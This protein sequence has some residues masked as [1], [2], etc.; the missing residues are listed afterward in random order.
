M[1]SHLRSELLHVVHVYLL[2]SVVVSHDRY[3]VGYSPP[4]WP[5]LSLVSAVPEL[6]SPIQQK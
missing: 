1:L 6:A 4:G 2:V 3:S 5:G